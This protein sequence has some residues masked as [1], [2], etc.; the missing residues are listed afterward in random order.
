MKG[1]AGGPAR[2]RPPTAGGPLVRPY[3]LTQGRTRS[4][5]AAQLDLISIVVARNRPAGAS[6]SLRGA[7]GDGGTARRPEHAAILRSCRSPVSVAEISARLD[8]PV[9]VAKVLVGDL[10]DTGDV[11][12]TAPPT[13]ERPPQ[14]NLLQ[15]VLDGIRRL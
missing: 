3:A 14:M 8:L 6:D 4:A 9:T 1:P 7:G 12:A 15:A 5:A 10:L 2:P 11:V 13:A